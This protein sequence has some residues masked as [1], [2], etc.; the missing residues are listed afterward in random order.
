VVVVSVRHRPVSD[1][2]QVGHAA[3]RPLHRRHRLGVEAAR[4]ADVGDA[5]EVSDG[6][7]QL[8][9]RSQRTCLEVGR[10]QVAELHQIRLQRSRT[11]LYSPKSVAHDIK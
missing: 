3:A 11:R 4:L 10:R 2:Q 6:S 1:G 7:A 9:L 8:R 5:L